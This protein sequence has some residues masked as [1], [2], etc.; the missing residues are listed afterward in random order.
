MN[1]KVTIS[2]EVVLQVARITTLATPGV[3]RLVEDE[4]RQ[5]G[6]AAS[7]SVSTAGRAWKHSLRGIVASIENGAAHIR[8]HIIAASNI[9][10]TQLA[11]QIQLNVAN[12]IA[13]IVGIETASV[14]VTIEDVQTA[15]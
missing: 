10:L 11:R 8:V 12:A 7:S 2:P 5:S 14:D 9:S 4:A 15:S 1:G 6:Q 13:E 3:L